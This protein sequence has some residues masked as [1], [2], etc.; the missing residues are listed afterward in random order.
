MVNSMIYLQIIYLGKD[1]DC[2][3]SLNMN[4]EEAIFIVKFLPEWNEKNEIE[5]T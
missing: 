2:K 4:F 3:S 1:V 5:N